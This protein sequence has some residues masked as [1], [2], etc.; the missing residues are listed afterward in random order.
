MIECETCFPSVLDVDPHERIAQ[1]EREVEGL[2]PEELLR[3]GYAALDDNDSLLAL[4][5]LE[6]ASTTV[7]SPELL[8]NLAFCRAKELARFDEATALCRSALGRDPDNTIHYLNLG[9]ILLMQGK[10]KAAMEIF[11]EGLRHGADPRISADLQLLGARR[12]PVIPFLN[13]KHLLNQSLGYILDRARLRK[14]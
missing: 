4:V 2:M 14:H 6:Q 12:R 10:K 1:L 11:A 5:C 7:D 8:S 13:R 9:R 3:R